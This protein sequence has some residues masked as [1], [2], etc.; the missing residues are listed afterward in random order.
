MVMVLGNKRFEM[1]TCQDGVAE[2]K[3]DAKKQETTNSAAA[4]VMVRMVWFEIV[5]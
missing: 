5:V 3:D 2:D 4:A 1:L